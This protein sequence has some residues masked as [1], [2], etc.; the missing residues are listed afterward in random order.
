M[1][2]QYWQNLQSRERLLLL[3]AAV[4]LAILLIH[5]LLIEPWLQQTQGL[6]HSIDTQQETLQWMQQASAELAALR[7]DSQVRRGAES[8]QSLMGRIDASARV[9]GIAPAIRQLRPDP[10]GV[11]VRL[12]NASFDDTLRWLGDLYREQGIQ[13][14]TFTME[15]L[16]EVGRINVSVSLSR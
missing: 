4:V 15:R 9:A 16:P 11:T 10:Q 13:V 6:R 8:G 3:G 2:Q 1:M 7:G 14:T 5:L 12:E